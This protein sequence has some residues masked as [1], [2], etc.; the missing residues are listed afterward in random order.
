MLGAPVVRQLRADGFTVRLLA[1]DPQKARSMHED[2]EVVPGDVTDLESLEQGMEGCSGVHI[3]VGGPAD[4]GSAENVAALAP[5]LGVGRI[6]YLSGSTVMEENRWFPM[7]GAKLLAEGAIRGCGVPYTLFCPTWPMEQ[8]PR[9][10]INGRATLWGEHPTPLHWFAAD[11][12]GV[13]VSNAYQRDEAVNKRLY[14]HGPEGIKFQEALERYRQ[15]FHPEIDP[16]APV[17]IEAASEMAAASGNPMLTFFAEMMAYFDQVGE[18]G[19][20]AEANRILGAPSTTLDA[21]IER[22]RARMDRVAG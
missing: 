10:I 1:R 9:F 12:L 20:P 15:A 11:D 7:V 17:P 13:M 2:V 21:W 4:Q 8:L 19:D 22:C 5:R 6:S 3:S 16:V 14:V 18:F